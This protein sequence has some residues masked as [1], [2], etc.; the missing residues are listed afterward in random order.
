MILRCILTCLA[1]AAWIFGTAAVAQLDRPKA[2]QPLVD[3]PYH[4]TET[5]LP[6]ADVPRRI[7][8]GN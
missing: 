1:S 2:P 5:V 4:V 6:P 7:A 8:A 3:L